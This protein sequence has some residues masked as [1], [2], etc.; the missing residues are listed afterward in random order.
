MKHRAFTRRAIRM[1]AL[2]ALVATPVVVLSAGPA[3][4]AD[5]TTDVELEDAFEDDGVTEIVLQNDI[6]ITSAG[7]GC[8]D[9]E[10]GGNLSLLINGQGFTI[11]KAAECEGDRI[12]RQFGSGTI[13]FQNVTVTGGVKFGGSGGALKTD[14]PVVVNNSTF[15]A[16]SVEPCDQVDNEVE[17]EDNVEA[18]GCSDDL[19]GG[20][21]YAEGSVN[22][23]SSVFSDNHSEGGGGIYTEANIIVTDSLFENNTA[24][25]DGDCW[26]SGGGFLAEG[27]ADVDASQFSGNAAG[28][29]EGCQGSGGGFWAANA[30]EVT[31]STFDG[32][33]AGCDFGCAGQGGGFSAN[34]YGE[35]SVAAGEIEAQAA[36]PGELLVHGTVFSGNVA[37]CDFSLGDL[38]TASSEGSCGSGGGFFS[39]GADLVEVGTSTFTGNQAICNTDAEVSAAGSGFCG[40]GGGFYA[41]SAEVTNVDSSTFDHNSATLFGGAIANTGF[42][43]EFNQEQVGEFQLTIVNSTITENTSG[44]LGAV[45]APIVFLVNNTIVGNSLDLSGLLVPTEGSFQLGANLSAFFAESFGTIN[46]GGFGVGFLSAFTGN[47][48]LLE[49]D[50]EGYNFSDD[51]TCQLDDPTDNVAEGNDPE[52]EPLG[53]YGG[54]TQTMRPMGEIDGG[55]GDIVSLSPVVDQIP[56]GECRVDV[57][58]R[59]VSRPQFIEALACDIGSVEITAEEITVAADVVTVTPRFT[60]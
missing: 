57:D 52:L 15:I 20:A 58:Q 36:D 2:V 30:A 33:E 35:R 28:C 53:N 26:C 9:F 60:G 5:V 37:R 39:Y 13:T 55:T 25:S 44:I 46:T 12:F 38:E 14:G 50:S 51:E 59:G 47:C 22:V 6:T 32:N 27:G 19:Y 7:A 24:T 54:P 3:A 45:T 4:A 10:R 42:F 31:N 23:T 40:G 1:L 18:E 41:R 17:G 29:E 8:G 48:L 34:G 21:I 16:N 49:G 11:T 43:S 56:E